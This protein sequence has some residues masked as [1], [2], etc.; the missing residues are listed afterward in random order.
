MKN[1]KRKN[2]GRSSD[3]TF[4][5]LT[6]KYDLKWETWRRLAEEWMLLQDT[7]TADKLGAICIF[8]DKY[9]INHVPWAV[10]IVSLFEKKENGE[11]VSSDQLKQVILN[12]TNRADSENLVK[13][14]NHVSNFID[15]VLIAYLSEEDDNGNLVKLYNNPFKTI[16]HKSN[17]SETVYNPLPYRYICQLRSILCP[18]P[19][20]SFSDW[21]W[22][23]NLS[24][25]IANGSGGWFDVDESKI[26][27]NDKDCVWRI[28][29]EK[30][31]RKSCTI[32][33]IWSPVAAMVLFIKLHLPL[34]TYQIRMLDSGE[35]D[36][37]RYEKAT[38]VKNEKHNFVIKNRKNGVFNY[39]R[40][41][42]TGIIST[43]LYINTNKTA[44]QNKNKLEKGYKIPWQHE[45]VLFWLEKLRNWQEKYN[46][47]TYLTDCTTLEVKHT[48][49]K[50]SDAYL[51]SMGHVSFLMRWASA[52]EAKDR[53][54]PV[55]HSLIASIWYKL[56]LQLEK[57]LLK[58]GDTLSDGTPLQLVKE[59]DEG[60]STTKVKTEFPLHSLRVSLITCY[61]VDAKI[62]LP[63]VSKLLAGHS[64]MLMT[65]HYTKLTPAVMNEKMI[66]A[67]Y[68]LTKNQDDDVRL[69]I[70]NAEIQQIES[71]MAYHN[72]E[73]IK[74]ALI[75]RN[76]L[77]WEKRYHGLCL[78]GGNTIPS[79]EVKSVAGCWNGGELIHNQNNKP[80]NSAVPHGPE[81]CV[82][83][84]WF[85]TDASY[86]PALNAHLNFMSYKAHDAAK[87]AKE[88]EVNIQD[89]EESKYVAEINNQAFQYQN[90][91]QTFQRR[92]EKQIIEADEFIKD[93]IAT[94]G[95]IR[96][97]IEIEKERIKTDS[98]NKLVA[99][100]SVNDI[101]IGFTETTSELLHLSLLCEDAEIFP[102]L[103]DDIKKTSIIQ[104][105]TLNLSRIMMHAGYKPYLLILDQEQQLMAANALM[106]QMAMQANPNEKLEGFK[107]ITNYL[108]LNQFLSNK[109]LLDNGINA[110]KHRIQIK[111][112]NKAI[113][114]RKP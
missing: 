18:D 96:R 95:L 94:F 32:Y 27:K 114:C 7:G 1:K 8:F 29:K 4:G 62:P 104:E 77:G 54:K 57:D 9:L 93:W 37:L 56:L 19:S 31:S 68:N 49:H 112:F 71:N 51:K 67:E 88:L 85:I 53:S 41:N 23:Q 99:V 81:N 15:W 100:G 26:D 66:E 91:L 106:R 20:G 98:T 34:R 60:Y 48:I 50:K 59:Y 36:A 55:C 75:N 80:S 13:L 35:A 64:R 28:R 42:A 3:L 78:V 47:I 30:K 5:W 43:G 70:K 33:Q 14:I 113:T 25:Q 73:S 6:K 65:I 89:L 61:L 101:K 105:R 84:R 22:A 58:S 17:F 16:K 38:W 24:P 109:K 108:E 72:I 97:I 52:S 45:I 107:K 111:S 69:F 40:D 102:D 86:L 2:D 21:Q 11:Y 110:L 76:P 103:Y 83:C 10:N 46:P 90:E 87:L 92:Y 74:V 39:Y 12:E 44:D 79:S 63:V 82:R